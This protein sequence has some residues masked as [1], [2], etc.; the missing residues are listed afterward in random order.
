MPRYQKNKNS[1]KSRKTYLILVEGTGQ[2]KCEST[3]FHFLKDV[4]SIDKK[5]VL[6]KVYADE[7]KINNISRQN[8]KDIKIAILDYDC[9]G[10]NAKIIRLIRNNY[11]IYLTNPDWEWWM[12]YHY[13][14]NKNKS[15]FIEKNDYL[16][17]EN[18]YTQN[19]SAYLA[20]L[21]EAIASSKRDMIQNKIPLL[22]NKISDFELICSNK[23]DYLSTNFSM[24]G[25]F[26]DNL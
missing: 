26:I 22:I 6:F 23:S 11:T 10:N 5:K 4:P 13:S 15:E 2:N 14:G 12:T 8:P 24:V 17:T 20:N 3:Y 7:S 9:G 1:F 21:N 25:T 16:K 18:W 19:S